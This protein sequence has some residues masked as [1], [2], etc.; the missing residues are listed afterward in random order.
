MKTF[1]ATVEFEF[2]LEAPEE[3]KNY[4]KTKEECEKASVTKPAYL[5]TA[6]DNAFECWKHGILSRCEAKY[7]S[8]CIVGPT[9]LKLT[10]VDLTVKEEAK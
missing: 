7:A 1:R 9:K 5:D 8:P 4:L 3:L 6:I 2:Y 10:E